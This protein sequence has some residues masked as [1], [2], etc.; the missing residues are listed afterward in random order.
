MALITA[1]ELEKKTGISYSNIHLK[2]KR[3]G[4]K[5]T[6]KKARFNVGQSGGEY[7]GFKNYYDE[8]KAMAVLK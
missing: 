7:S 5:A 6:K 2:L 1:Q 4:I 8:D 3:F